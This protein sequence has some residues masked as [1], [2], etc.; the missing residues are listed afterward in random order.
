MDI[1]EKILTLIMEKEPILPL[2]AQKERK[3]NNTT[4]TK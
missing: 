1:T 2:P 4:G 3:K